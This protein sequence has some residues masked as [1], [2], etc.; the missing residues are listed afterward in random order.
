MY[1]IWILT[2]LELSFVV[3]I[4]FTMLVKE[5]TLWHLRFSKLTAVLFGAVLSITS[6]SYKG[7]NLM[8]LTLFGVGL[9]FYFTR[10]LI[11]LERKNTAWGFLPELSCYV[12]WTDLDFALAAMVLCCVHHLYS[13][14]LKQSMMSGQCFIWFCWS[15]CDVSGI[16]KRLLQIIDLSPLNFL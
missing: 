6:H 16:K 14:V 4:T 15:C 8:S 5:L 3:L 12:L 10:Y 13:E 7:K 11:F 2:D 1:F 9:L